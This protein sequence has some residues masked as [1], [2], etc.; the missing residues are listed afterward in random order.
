M[1]FVVWDSKTKNP[2]YAYVMHCN[3]LIM[4]NKKQLLIMQELMLLSVVIFMTTLNTAA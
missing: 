1:C 3:T 4:N 2:G